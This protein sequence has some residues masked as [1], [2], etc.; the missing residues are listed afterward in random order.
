MSLEVSFRKELTKPHHRFLSGVCIAAVGL[1][2]SISAVHADELSDLKKTMAEMSKRLEKLEKDKAA[3][4]QRQKVIE[5]NGGQA[6]KA[7]AF[8]AAS[9]IDPHLP[10]P[11]GRYAGYWDI[12]GTTT[13]MKIGGSIRIDGFENFNN[14]MGVPGGDYRSIPLSGSNNAKRGPNFDLSARNTQLTFGTITQTPWADVKTFVSVDFDAPT[15]GN[16]YVTNAFA[17]R[18]REAYAQADFGENGFLVGQTWSTFMDLI[19]Y[20][21]TL[22]IDGPTGGV[23][24]RQPVVRYTRDLGG[25]NKV[26]FAIESS[27]SDFEGSAT[28]TILSAGNIPSANYSTPLPDFVAKYSHDAEWGH[29][30]IGGLVRYIKLDTGGVGLAGGT[31]LLPA[32]A[33]GTSANPLVPTADANWGGGAMAALTV[34]TFGKD[35]VNFEVSGGSG[36]GRYQYGDID[37]KNAASLVYCNAAHT[38][39]CGLDNNETVGGMASYQHWWTS[40]LRTNIA[41]G[42]FRFLTTEFPDNPTASARDITSASANLIWEPKPGVQVGVEYEWGRLNV[43]QAPAVGIGTTGVASHIE[44]TVKYSF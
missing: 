15:V 24:V 29:F 8:P 12:P 7:A 27:N 21:E 38:V 16:T 31:N 36:I 22:D 37:V 26:D 6:L 20:P 9:V 34:K 11:P 42:Y 17:P 39:V 43:V 10:S 19:S 44:T 25:G 18:L 23:Y 14:G 32:A 30:A 13:S 5:A 41:G 35:T 28:Q 4:A 33:I 1:C 40:N 3:M 2:F